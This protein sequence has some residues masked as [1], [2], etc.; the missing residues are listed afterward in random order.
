MNDSRRI[1]NVRQ[2]SQVIPTEVFEAWAK[3]E[4]HVGDIPSISYTRLGT[5]LYL[6]SCYTYEN[7]PGSK[8]I[9]S[10][11]ARIDVNVLL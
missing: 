9:L 7:A 10:G 4:Y 8:N 6:R 1:T 3:G 2:P 11:V 5:A